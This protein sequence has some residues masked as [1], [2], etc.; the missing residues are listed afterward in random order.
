MNMARRPLA[1]ITADNAD[2]EI[3]VFS[4]RWDKVFVLNHAAPDNAIN[5]WLKARYQ[6]VHEGPG[7]QFQFFVALNRSL[8]I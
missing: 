2:V 8:S 5:I 3:A 4:D 6:G 1:R 7:V